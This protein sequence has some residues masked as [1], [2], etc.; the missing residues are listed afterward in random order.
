[1]RQL[2]F[3]DLYEGFEPK[4]D[5]EEFM[6]DFMKSINILRQINIQRGFIRD[7]SDTE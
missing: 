2:K 3:S 6:V 1:M 4:I 7:D 5:D